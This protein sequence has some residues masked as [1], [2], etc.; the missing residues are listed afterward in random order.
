MVGKGSLF[1]SS[2]GLGSNGQSAQSGSSDQLLLKKIVEDL[3]NVMMEVET[4]LKRSEVT[5]TLALSSCTPSDTAGLLG[6]LHDCF[7]D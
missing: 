7:S 3:S 5:S 1:Q 6:K 2:T 4:E